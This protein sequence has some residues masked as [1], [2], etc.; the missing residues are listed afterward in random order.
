MDLRFPRS[1][2]YALSGYVLSHSKVTL[3]CVTQEVHH[4][5]Y[6]FP[7]DADLASPH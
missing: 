1:I 6:T 7:F 3:I 2:P 4:N 5:V